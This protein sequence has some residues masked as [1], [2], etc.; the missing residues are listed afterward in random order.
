MEYFIKG[1]VIG[2]A[3][4]AP[5]GPIGI[6]CIQRSLIQG[7]MH[8]VISGIGAATADAVYGFIAAFGLTVISNFLI[9]QK[10]WFQII[11]GCFLCYL[12]IRT[13]FSRPTENGS[14]INKG[15][16]ITAYTSTMFL[17]ITN[18][19]TVLS[20]MAIFSGLG[21]AAENRSLIFSVLLVLGVF[22]GSV[23]WWVL[24]S[25]GVTLIKKKV[26]DRFMIWINRS[27][28]LILLIFGLMAVYY[29]FT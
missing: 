27:S 26:N 15:S 18:P 8:G 22:A 6:L 12:G 20:F 9:S 2:F 10:I 28:G 17:T 25:L 24:L 13:F 19:M 29:A 11:G 21:L 4:A 7:K 14:E 3:I 16:L 1:L 23:L 5:V